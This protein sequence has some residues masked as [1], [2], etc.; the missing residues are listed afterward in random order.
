MNHVGEVEIDEITFPVYYSDLGM[1]YYIW[2][3]AGDDGKYPQIIE[4]QKETI[5]ELE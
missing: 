4:Y 2:R 1:Y 3:N 5:N